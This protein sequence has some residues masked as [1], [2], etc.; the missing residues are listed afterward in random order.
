MQLCRPSANESIPDLE[1]PTAN[2]QFLDLDTLVLNGEPT[3]L[4]SI[5]VFGQVV[6]FFLHP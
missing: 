6:L 1:D 4:R 3:S 5:H 2:S